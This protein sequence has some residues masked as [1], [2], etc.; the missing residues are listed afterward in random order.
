MDTTG[1]GQLDSMLIDTN[2]DGM[3]DTIVKINAGPTPVDPE[4]E[5]MK[6]EL[7]MLK[8]TNRHAEEQAP[9]QRDAD[10][11]RIQAM[12]AQARRQQAEADARVQAAFGT[13]RPAAWRRY[14]RLFRQHDGQGAHC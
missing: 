9:R 13:P 6:A 2:G 10:N 5:R 7:A 11:A 3:P 1:D 8:E 4:V 14:W 12:E